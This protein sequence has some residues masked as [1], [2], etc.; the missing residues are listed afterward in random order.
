LVELLV[1]IAIIG[2]LIALLLPAVQAAR[3]AA[4]RSQCTNNMKQLSLALHAHHDSHNGFPANGADTKG[5]PSWGSAFLSLLP[6][7]EMNARHE[8]FVAGDS[9]ISGL[10]VATTD[11]GCRGPI[12]A[13]SCPS[14]DSQHVSYS[15]DKK[16]AATNY[17]VSYGD[18][19]RGTHVLGTSKRGI[20]GG[21][22]I[23][24]SFASTTDGTSN[25]IAFS[26][27]LV[28]QSADDS[29]LGAGIAVLPNSGVPYIAKPGS[30][31]AFR[32]ANKQILSN[33]TAKGVC[34]R[35]NSFAMG[36]GIYTGFSTILP[37]NS[38]SGTDRG[39]PPNIHDCA[40]LMSA[41]SN[42]TGGVNVGLCDGSVTFVSDT[43]NALTGGLVLTD[44]DDPTSGPSPFGIWGA[45]GTIDGSESKSF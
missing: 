1:V 33:D 25:T 5:T 17:V 2:V 45:M 14:D 7:L 9:P 23:Y 22:K 44:V 18:T 39:D 41:A 20:F 32:G 43:I 40:G 4:R 28:A 27:T 11:E 12:S 31:A 37:P 6:F 21:Q 16:A 29:R 35:G 36:A 8:R 13:F 42:H 3:E 19:T 26:E 34:G 30:V 15:N 38:P 24:Q 10:F